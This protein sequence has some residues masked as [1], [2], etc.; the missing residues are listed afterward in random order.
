MEILSVKELNL[1]IEG[2]D[3]IKDGSFSISSGDVVL[4]TGPNGCGK[5]TFITVLL[6]AA[7]DYKDL[8]YSNSTVLYRQSHSILSSEKENAFFRN[9]IVY[10]SQ[11]DEFESDSVLDCFVN[12]IIGFVDKNPERYVFDFIKQFEIQGCFYP[13]AEKTHL[14]RKAIRLL[15]LNC[16]V[17]EISDKE[18]AIRHINACRDCLN[19]MRDGIRL[20]EDNNT[21]FLAFQL[22]N[23]AML[24]QQLHYNLPLQTWSVD[25]QDHLYLE[26]VIDRM[27]DINDRSTWYQGNKRTYGKWRPFQLAF[28]LINLRSMYEKDC[29][30]R[31]LVDLIWFPTGGGKT[32]AYLGLDRW[33]VIMKP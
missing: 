29:H 21:V 28:V 19:R 20:L 32:E 5:S 30:D 17:P 14:A 33:S 9:N 16:K 12:S 11:E 1:S 4:L 22:M 10:V 6:G 15:S 7:F 27:P 8:D 26:N 3:L 2:K 18:T 13:A 25:Q 31:G 24:L 23:R